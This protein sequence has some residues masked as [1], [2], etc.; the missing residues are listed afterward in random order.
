[1]FVIPSLDGEERLTDAVTALQVQG[2]SFILQ[3][4]HLANTHSLWDSLI[5]SIRLH[6]GGWIIQGVRGGV[7]RRG[8]GAGH[9]LIRA[10]WAATYLC[11]GQR[12]S[13]GWAH[14]QDPKDF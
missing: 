2:I 11:S 4:E 14:K 7:R 13:D 12:L 8:G 3:K 9:G 6:V 1:M 10:E 5:L